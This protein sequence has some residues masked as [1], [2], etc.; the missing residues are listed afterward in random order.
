MLK[1]AL[2]RELR[3]TD[4]E[5]VTRLYSSVHGIEKKLTDAG[6]PKHRR[7]LMPHEAGFFHGKFGP[8]LAERNFGILRFGSSHAEKAGAKCGP[9]T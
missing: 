8:V 9:Q 6:N 1:S 2:A 5:A 3:E 7:D 4:S